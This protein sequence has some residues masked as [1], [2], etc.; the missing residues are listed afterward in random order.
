MGD[1]VS[2][3]GVFRADLEPPTDVDKVLKAA[4]GLN[5]RDVVYVGRTL[6]GTLV[7]GASIADAD[8]VIGLLARGANW[9][10][11]G[12]QASIASEDPAQ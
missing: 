11:E 3:P 8:A 7:L 6:D 9:L 5:L 4:L 12:P 1:V 10:A 2:L